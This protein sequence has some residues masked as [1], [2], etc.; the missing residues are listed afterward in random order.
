VR[1]PS[2]STLRSNV[3]FN[4]TPRWALQWGT[5]Y[6]FEAH[7]FSDHFVTLQ[8]EFR[9]WLANFSFSSAPNG[10]FAFSFYIAL[11]AAPDLKFNYD[12]RSYRP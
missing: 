9:D 12:R 6:D 1:F 11:K 5:G 8:R 2:R 3:M 10:N 4:L 7:R